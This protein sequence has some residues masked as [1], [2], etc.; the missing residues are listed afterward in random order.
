MFSAG[1]RALILIQIWTMY[2]QAEACFWTAEEVDLSKDLCQWRDVLTDCERHFL[3]R[4]LAFFATA[5][6][7][8]G[9][10]VLLHFASEVQIPEARCFYGFQLMM[11]NIHA[12]MYSL[13]IDS[14]VQDPACRAAL[15]SAISGFPSVAAKA[16]WALDCI[17]DGGMSFAQRLIVFAAVEGIFFSSSFASIFW[18]RKRGLLPGLAHAND[19]IA[20]DEGLHTRFACVLYLSLQAALPHDTVHAV[21]RE[22]VGLE[23]AFIAGEQHCLSNF[24]VLMP[25]RRNAHGHDWYERD[26]DEAI[27][28]IRS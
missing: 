26:V 5:D 11:E 8:V 12:E 2:K 24:H 14:L 3:S 18:M 21:I 25:Y 23:H 1:P 15:F 27:R 16:R 9:E 7:I 20:R 4:V 22:A 10:N 28:R 13:L 17:Q 6:G 19:L